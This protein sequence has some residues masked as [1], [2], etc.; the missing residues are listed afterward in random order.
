M[1]IEPEVN[2]RGWRTCGVRIGDR[3]CPDWQELPRLM[4]EWEHG[5][6]N[7]TPDEA[8]LE[9]EKIHPFVDGNGR[10]GKIIH[11]WMLKSLDKPVLIKDYFGWGNP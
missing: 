10:T 6:E 4:L 7:L 5:I 2:H 1:M 3:I 11:N 9:F 8:Y